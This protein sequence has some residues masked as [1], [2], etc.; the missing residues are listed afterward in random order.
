MTI[1]IAGTVTDAFRL[2]PPGAMAQRQ[3]GRP[4]LQ[5]CVQASMGAPA[6]AALHRQRRRA[7]AALLLAPL[8]FG[9]RPSSSSSG[10]SAMWAK[11]SGM[12]TGA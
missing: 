11:H 6:V 9:P 10:G 8:L 1:A 4:R 12:F 2:V 3:R 7:G 5:S